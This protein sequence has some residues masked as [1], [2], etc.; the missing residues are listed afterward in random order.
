MASEETSLS[1]PKRR[2]R[3]LIRESL[4]S[5]TNTLPD[6]D[7]QDG[8]QD[9]L[10]SA[11]AEPP[12]EPRPD[13]LLPR[14]LFRDFVGRHDSIAGILDALR[15]KN[16]YLVTLTGMGGVGKTRLAVE[17]GRRIAYGNDEEARG[18][19][20]ED[21]VRFVNLADVNR[22]QP[23]PEQVLWS[24]LIEQL[25]LKSDDSSL[26]LVADVTARLKQS[27]LDFL[28]S[29]RLLLVLDNCEHLNRQALSSVVKAICD[30][31]DGDIRVLAT[32]RK[33]LGM[34]SIER[35]V[36]VDVLTRPDLEGSAD[37]IRRNEAVELFISRARLAGKVLTEA[38]LRGDALLRYIARICLKVD[39]I[40]LAIV[41]A[42]SRVK[43]FP[44]LDALLAA[45]D[46]S[47][48]VLSS[49]ATD[50]PVRQK[51]LEATIGWSYNLLEDNKQ[52]QLKGYE[53][54]QFFRHLAVFRAGW[55]LEDV[56]KVCPASKDDS[57]RARNLLDSLLD[58]RLIVLREA[59]G[60]PIY[61][62]LDTVG[63]DARRRFNTDAKREEVERKHCVYFAKMLLSNVEALASGESPQAAQSV[64]MHESNIVEA[65][66]RVKKEEVKKEE[67]DLGIQVLRAIENA[68][69]DLETPDNYPRFRRLYPFAVACRE[70]VG[71]LPEG[72]TLDEQKWLKKLHRGMELQE[73]FAGKNDWD[74]LFG[75]E[76]PSF[77][78]LR[79]SIEGE[80]WQDEALCTIAVLANMQEKDQARLMFACM[81][82]VTFDW[83]EAYL[84]DGSKSEYLLQAWEHH[85]PG[86]SLGKVLRAFCK[87]YP[88]SSQWRD[89]H[90]NIDLWEDAANSLGE[91][92]DL[93]HV[94]IPV[95]E[96]KTPVQKYLRAI[97][98]RYLAEA[99]NYLESPDKPL[100]QVWQQRFLGLFKA[101]PKS[102]RL[103]AGT[104]QAGAW[105]S[106]FEEA[107]DLFAEGK[108]E[109]K[110]DF[111]K[112]W[113]MYAFADALQKE[114]DL[115]G[116]RQQCEAALDSELGELR[117][118][119]KKQDLTRDAFDLELLANL[120]RVMADVHYQSREY[121]DALTHYSAA[122]FMAYVFLYT[123]NVDEYARA[124]YGEMVD[125][126]T[127]CLK[128]LVPNRP[129][130]RQAFVDACER[131]EQFW[132]LIREE[133]AP[134][135]FNAQV[136]Q[137]AWCKSIRANP[138]ALAMLLFPSK[139]KDVNDIADAKTDY[140]G[141]IV[142]VVEAMPGHHKRWGQKF[143][144]EKGGQLTLPHLFTEFAA[145][146]CKA[147]DELAKK[148][149]Q[150]QE[151]AA[152]A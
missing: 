100:P 114:G 28:K 84:K 135:D 51:T 42:A 136:G 15:N 118:L 52:K 88:Q 80:K 140:C 106:L 82:F 141:K 77:N 139:P 71:A 87:A 11:G 110:D 29:K 143:L 64:T 98:N 132:R 109:E 39:C 54:K 25:Q 93:L 44:T 57:S 112:Q 148:T 36:N 59:P 97:A 81:Y 138:D 129:S 152:G 104:Q 123:E 55:T 134:T 19:R 7:E 47:L 142:S 128:D 133:E 122:V 113:A 147:P 145:L 68:L 125:R 3:A 20:F 119:E 73:L 5:I 83:W 66:G 131:A 24:K 46:E 53:Q 49:D 58:A 74:V 124:M 33:P 78:T 27:V 37:A 30:Q 4:N 144:K 86:D 22:K 121:V 101:S 41:L 76:E 70:L 150:V 91:V 149:P 72:A 26:R 2:A 94:N 61:R 108:E 79:D 115:K 56:C 43:D 48:D 69:P 23:D 75:R 95:A 8:E 9:A 130:D 6:A 111:N 14:T 127:D 90:K 92:Q 31:S 32:S 96:L 63:K 116:A 117:E 146:L 85:H 34:E 105:R 50:M 21:G 1:A 45:L 137:V 67:P 38:D 126:T 18:V 12:T 107:I 16:E 99:L 62:F 60:Q 151:D 13:N 40:P 35:E 17:V 103:P 10:E 89:R 65:L 102:R 120:Y